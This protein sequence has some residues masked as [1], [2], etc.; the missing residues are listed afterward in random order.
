MLFRSADAKLE[1]LLSEPILQRFQVNPG[2]LTRTVVSCTGA[3]FCNFAMIETKQYAVSVIDAV[4]AQV[5]VPKPVRIHWTGC[6]NSL[7]D[8]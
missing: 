3:Q 6:P 4:E 2:N 1:T 8:F 5:D 7:S